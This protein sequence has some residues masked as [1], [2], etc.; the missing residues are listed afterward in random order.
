MAK[1]FFTEEY[2]LTHIV[3]KPKRPSFRDL[4]GKQINKLH[5]LEYAGVHKKY[6]FWW[7]ICSCNTERYFKVNGNSLIREITGSC[8]CNYKN[9]KI[10]NLHESIHSASN[11]LAE[12]LVFKEFS[13]WNYQCKIYCTLCDSNTT[14][15]KANN[16]RGFKCCY[17][18]SKATIEENI[19]DF[20]YKYIGDSIGECEYCGHSKVISLIKDKCQCRYIKTLSG[21]K[22]S[23]VYIL[24]DDTETY[25]KIGKSIDPQVRFEN[26]NKSAL[27]SEDNLKFSIKNI[28]W[29]YNERLSY[30]LESRLHQE[31]KNFNVEGLAKFDGSTEVF[32]MDS[33]LIDNWISNNHDLLDN[34]QREDFQPPLPP[35]ESLFL[36]EYHVGLSVESRGM[37]FPSRQSY[38]EHVDIP[39]NHFKESLNFSSITW[40]KLWKPLKLTYDLE[41]LREKQYGVDWGDNLFGTIRGLARKYN[42]NDGTVFH[43]VRVLGYSMKEALTY[44][45]LN[46]EYCWE[47]GGKF[48]TKAYICNTVGLSSNVISHRLRK[49][50]PLEYAIIPD[51]WNKTG[52]KD[53]IYLLDGEAYWWADLSYIFG[54]TKSRG[55]VLNKY[56]TVE[57]WLLQENLLKEGTNFQEIIF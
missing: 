22:A 43:R 46:L 16:A 25:L 21:D 4:S 27:K 49:G 30:W 17:N 47:I 36:S 32:K 24:Q 3:E 23:A 52:V 39:L 34:L 42:V 7:C 54:N 48:Y 15:S 28:I 35:V 10:T 56:P 50:V 26:I 57:N 33:S 45:N 53:A 41:M 40:Y 6:N 31:F 2:Y 12:H 55:W 51:R 8:G 19:K 13:G 5:V 9:N 1:Q 11:R 29:V 44:P 37:W 14:F 18:T 20:G 38:C